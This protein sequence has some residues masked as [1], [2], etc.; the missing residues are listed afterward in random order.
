MVLIVAATILILAIAFFQAVQG[1]FSALLMTIMTLLCSA[2]AFG[3]YE[4][5]AQL[6][7]SRQPAYADAAALMTLFV[8]PLLGLRLLGDKFIPGNVVLGA[9]ANRIVGGALGILTGTVMVGMLTLAL[10]MLPFGATVMTFRPFD[11]SLRRQRSLAPFYCDQFTV[12]LAEVLSAGSLAGGTE[13]STSHEDLLLEAF[14]ARNTAEL[15]GRVDAVPDALKG[16]E[17]FDPPERRLARWRDDVPD[18]PLFETYQPS[19]IIVVRCQID[20]SA[21]DGSGQSAAR[22]RWR[23]PATHFRLVTTAGHSYYPLAYL[24]YKTDAARG[25]KWQA[26]PAAVEGDR[27]QIARLAV[28]R[29]AAK[30]VKSIMVDWVYR[31]GEDDEPR[32]VVFRRVAKKAVTRK[33]YKKNQMPDIRTALDRDGLREE[34]PKRRRS[35]K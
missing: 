2:L 24:T 27:A 28:V 31:I 19:K 26:H 14:C 18:N 13:L 34:G 32:Y 7:Y 1:V 35:R 9:W 12:G 33:T 16:I 22:Q 8:L 11:D 3:L 20:A 29:P 25:K 21:R 17:V 6:F 15:H 4:P 23:L 10:Q 5:L 30:E